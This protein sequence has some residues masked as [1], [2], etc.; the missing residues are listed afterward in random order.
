MGN[1][2]IQLKGYDYAIKCEGNGQLKGVIWYNLRIRA[3]PK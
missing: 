1:V 3:L 2:N